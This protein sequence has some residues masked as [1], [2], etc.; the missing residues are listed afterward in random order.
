VHND[1][2]PLYSKVVFQL[3]NSISFMKQQVMFR[4]GSESVYA[5]VE[6]SFLLGSSLEQLT[7]ELAVPIERMDVI[8]FAVIY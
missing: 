7:F 8:I 3:C 6:F 5:Q 1:L 4:F 2:Y